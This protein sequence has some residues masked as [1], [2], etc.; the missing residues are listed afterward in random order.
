MYKLLRPALFALDPETSHDL[1]IKLLALVSRWPTLLRLIRQKPETPLNT[2][3]MGIEFPNPFGLAAGLDKNARCFPALAAMGFGFVELGTVTPRPQPGNPRPRLYR[4]REDRA[5]INRMGFNSAGLDQFVRNL[6]RL[7]PYCQAPI[8]INLGK[9]ALTP[10]EQ[11]SDDYILG[12]ERVYRHADYIAIN[13]SSPNTASLRDLQSDEALDQLLHRVQETRANLSTAV[14]IAVKLAP[15]LTPEQ[16]VA[17]CDVLLKRSIDA[18]IACNTTVQRPPGLI[19]RY[20]NQQGGL[21]GAPLAPIAI[22]L[23]EQLYRSLAGRIPLIGVGGIDSAVAALRS[24]AAGADLI[25]VYSGFIYQGGSL[26]RKLRTGLAQRMHAMQINKA[27]E[28][29]SRMHDHNEQ[30]QPFSQGQQ[31]K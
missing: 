29:I 21:S 9:N 15:D 1:V 31:S 11:A 7:K 26:V 14:P 8:G 2:T 4:L 30:E 3:V 12:L 28:A 20:R 19:S 22:S 23:Q 6:E 10:I 27:G 16:V 5:L 13:I 17:A 24:F 18:V 25:Q